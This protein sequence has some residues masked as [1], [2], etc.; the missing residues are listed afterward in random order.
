[1]ENNRLEMKVIEDFYLFL[2][3]EN[4]E[5]DL[6]N[7]IRD[8]IETI[9]EIIGLPLEV[10]SIKKIGSLE[11]E[12]TLDDAV[13]KFSKPQ[14]RHI[15]NSYTFYSPDDNYVPRISMKNVGDSFEL[16]FSH[17]DLREISDKSDLMEI[18]K[19]HKLYFLLK[20][21]LDL[22]NDEDR[23]N[24]M[25]YFED[26][27]KKSGINREGKDE[28]KMLKNIALSFSNE[29]EIGKFYGIL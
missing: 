3:N 12:A 17:P 11:Y 22:D 10:K 1:M 5:V 14:G 8:D 21:C 7:S 2:E 25:G 4:V 29:N 23:E 19:N 28:L 18:K 6:S 27:C 13:L 9:M 16:N 26:R 20:K 24:F 15:P